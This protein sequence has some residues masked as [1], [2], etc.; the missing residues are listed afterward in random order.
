MKMTPTITGRAPVATSHPTNPNRFAR[1]DGQ[2]RR[3]Q[4]LL[5]RYEVVHLDAK[6][7]IVD[8]NR[9]APALPAFEEAFSA[10]ARGT[11]FETDCG[12]VAVEDLLPGDRLKTVENG[13]QTL[14]WKG[15]VMVVPNIQRQS[16]EMRTLT[17]IASDTFGFARPQ[18]DLVLG[19]AARIFHQ[20]PSVRTLTGQ[21]GAFIPLRDFEDGIS[22]FSLSPATA[23]QCFHLAFEEQERI[24][25]DGIELESYH[26]GPIHRFPL[27]G[28]LLGVYMNLF[29]HLARVADI[30][31]P[32]YPRLKLQEL[33]IFDAA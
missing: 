28:D 3:D 1:T 31:A 32:R 15:S 26:P 18:R 33:D 7:D 17:R 11:V 10:F 23:V 8:F 30:T 2:P 24:L 20:A 16:P 6:G 19:P 29:P 25:A 13:Y 5:R 4:P 22:I 21:P 12:P 14:I 27:R 9:V